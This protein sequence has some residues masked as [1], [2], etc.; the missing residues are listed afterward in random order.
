MNVFTRTTRLI[1]LALVVGCGLWIVP[2]SVNAQSLWVS[3]A[4]SAGG[5]PIEV[6][7]F[8]TGPVNV[9]IVGSL[10]G[11]EPDTLELM[12]AT[13]RLAASHDP[14]EPVTLLLIR[15]LNPDGAV[16]LT[17]T[18]ARGVD[19][20]RNF[21]SHRF[22][23]IPNQLTGPYP[24]SEPETQYMLRVLEEYR[25]ARVIHVRSGIDES[26]LILINEPWMNAGGEPIL[27][28]HVLRSPFDKTYKAGSL[29]EFVTLQMNGHIATLTLARPGGKSIEAAD[30]LRLAIGQLASPPASMANRAEPARQVPPVQGGAVPGSNGA[31][32][33]Q[34]AG[35]GNTVS[36]SAMT[37]KPV[38]AKE[39]E[40]LPPPPEFEATGKK[41]SQASDVDSRYF[42]LP[43]PPH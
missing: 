15:T 8:G 16:D 7:R 21:P 25:P 11:N 17:R 38:A 37:A 2:T 19:L 43:P 30:L 35:S 14:P 9:L 34:S 42:E 33:N 28:P 22:T 36:P 4:K 24:A 32:P 20:V 3:T 23:R 13:C 29:E 31:V 39:V 1:R 12:D 5:R 40:L 41:P 6:A 18:N 27:P 10:H 26:P